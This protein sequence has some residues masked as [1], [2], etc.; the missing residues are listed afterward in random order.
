[1]IDGAF[2]QMNGDMDDYPDNF[3]EDLAAE[4]EMDDYY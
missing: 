3:E 4:L 1:M 2:G